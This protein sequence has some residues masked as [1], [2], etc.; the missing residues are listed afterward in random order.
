M[1]P[2]LGSNCASGFRASICCE[3]SHYIKG[4]L[5]GCKSPN[6]M[7]AKVSPCLSRVIELSLIY[8]NSSDKS[9]QTWEHLVTRGHFS[10][11]QFGLS[12]D[13]QFTREEIQMSNRQM[14]SISPSL[15]VTKMPK[16][17]F[18]SLSVAKV[19]TYYVAWFRQLH[20][21]PQRR[22]IKLVQPFPGN[23]RVTNRRYDNPFTQLSYF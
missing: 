23:R 7:E 21:L 20:S 8:M 15:A 3:G 6:Q 22:V 13:R 4:N 19:K 2:S 9:P 5:V 18:S 16:I 14:E 10:V 17:S 12:P 1:Q 11:T